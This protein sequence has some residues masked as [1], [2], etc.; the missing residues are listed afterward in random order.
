MAQLCVVARTLRTGRSRNS[1][2][3]NIAKWLS[4]CFL[5]SRVGKAET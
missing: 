5:D 2:I 1:R 3:F 4:A